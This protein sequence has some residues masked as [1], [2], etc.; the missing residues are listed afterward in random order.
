MKGCRENH[1]LDLHDKNEED[2]VV[3]RRH[4]WQY[5]EN[6][7]LLP[8]SY[9]PSKRPKSDIGQN[10][11]P[12]NLKENMIASQNSSHSKLVESEVL[13]GVQFFD[14]TSEIVKDIIIDVVHD[15]MDERS[16]KYQSIFEN[17]YVKEKES[18]TVQTV[19]KGII[20]NEVVPPTTT[21][22]STV[23]DVEQ[24]II[25]SDEMN[26]SFQ[27]TDMSDILD[28]LIDLT[29]KHRNICHMEATTAN[30]IEFSKTNGSNGSFVPNGLQDGAQKTN[31]CELEE[32]EYTIKN[33]PKYLDPINF[34]SNLLPNSFNQSL[35]PRAISATQHIL[36]STPSSILALHMTKLDSDML[37]PSTNELK[38][39][40]LLT[41]DETDIEEI[42][43]AFIL[44]VLERCVCLKTFVAVTILTAMNVRESARMCSKWIQIATH[45]KQKLGNHFGLYNLLSGLTETHLIQWGDL[46]ICLKEV[47]N[48]D[49]YYSYIFPNNI[50]EKYF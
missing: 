34:E 23:P 35:D 31:G 6:E 38:G 4:S 13:N 48:K 25:L 29:I 45:L 11:L 24:R 47:T 27:P 43:N 28:E 42:R 14:Q 37:L 32:S 17:D 44:N 2:G 19:N 8:D 5:A 18:E 15:A 21:I 33:S 50:F 1:V 49:E 40:G 16:D 10:E 3:L 36:L 26:G 46:W 7:L 12:L 39:L 30:K 9:F 41:S 20:D 22:I